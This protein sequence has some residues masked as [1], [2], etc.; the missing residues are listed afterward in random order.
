LSKFS[1][2]IY[3]GCTGVEKSDLS[4]LI[5]STGKMQEHLQ[6][7]EDEFKKIVKINF[8]APWFLLKA[9]GKRMRDYKSG[10]SIVFLTSIIGAERGIY[11][12]AAAYGSCMAGL[13]QLARVRNCNKQFFISSALVIFFCGIF[14]LNIYPS[15]ER[16]CT[17]ICI[18]VYRM[19][20]NLVDIEVHYCFKDS[21]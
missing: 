5:I 16:A 13:Q 19:L 1:I 12:G 4:L 14:C 20:I 18:Y 3:L 17:D 10:G 7:A 11:P 8:M 6:L 2:S 15:Q 21:I 9:V